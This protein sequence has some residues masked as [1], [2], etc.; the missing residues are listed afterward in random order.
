MT[1]ITANI[2]DTDRLMSSVGVGMWTW[3]GRINKLQLD[4]TCRGFFELDWDQETPQ[5]VL[6]EK[7]PAQDVEKYRQAV[8]E[9]KKTGRF[10]CEFCVN[11]SNGGIRY[12]SGRGHT[13]RQDDDN[14]V[15]KGVFIDVTATKELEGRFR[16]HQ[17]RMQHMVDGIPGLFSYLSKD[18]KVLFMS[19]QYR[20]I[21][22]KT[23]DQ[24][25]G[26]HVKELLGEEIFLERKP[27][28][29]EALAGNVVQLE[30]SRPMKDGNTNYYAV[31]HQPHIENDEVVGIIT[32]GIDITEARRMQSF[33]EAKSEELKRSNRDLEQFAYVAS[34]DLKS[35]LRAVEVIIEWLQEDLEGYKEGDVQENLNLLGQRTGRL[36]QLLDDLLAYSRAGRKVGDVKQIQLDEFVKDIAILIGPPEGMQIIAGENMPS[37]NTHHAALETVLR[38]LMSNAIKHHPDPANGHIEVSCMDQGEQVMISVT[39]DG[40]GI[41]EQYA[42]KVFK[43]FQTLQSR[44]ETEGSGMGL[45]IVQRI[46]DWQGG[47]ISF[48]NGPDGKGIT[49]KFTWNKTPQGM[50][51]ED[52]DQEDDQDSNK[53][54]EGADAVQ[55]DRHQHDHEHSDG[56]R[57]GHDTLMLEKG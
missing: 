33:V 39:D 29:D 14:H 6:E 9:C 8:I 38:N 27:R 41:P 46:I 21:F 17:S 2:G 7:L 54:V 32:L 53:S 47:D 13:I 34:H 15:I 28:Y 42:E 35:P 50:P 4:P 55:S 5:T 25:V 11:K 12:L 26:V 37:L 30:S 44:D 24:L 48:E 36:S 57:P 49:F 56:E 19:A 45:A 3:D 22:D 23:A 43:M 1:T 52:G 16:S 40:P 20:D 51:S 10:D 31:T 18:Y